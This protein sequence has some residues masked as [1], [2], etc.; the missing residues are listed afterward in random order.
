MPL[1]P[2]TTP[3]IWKPVVGYEGL[4][5]VSDLGRVRRVSASPYHPVNPNSDMCGSQDR[6]GYRVVT[7]S[8]NLACRNVGVHRLVAQAFLGPR[9]P[10]HITHHRNGSKADNRAANLEWVTPRQNSHHAVTTG[11]QPDHRGE[12]N[13][14]AKLTRAKV[15]VIR[16][17]R[18]LVSERHLAQEFG[19]S[20]GAIHDIQTRRRWKD[21]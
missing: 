16:S 15:A 21:V 5:E 8:S 1:N 13:P 11:L 10:D 20:H 6:N 17:L 14:A 9:P 19:V 7:L 18:G 3:E 4:Y 12:A 2:T